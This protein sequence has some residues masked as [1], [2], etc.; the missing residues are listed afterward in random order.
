MVVLQVYIKFRQRRV[1]NTTQEAAGI[2]REQVFVVDVMHQVYLAVTV[3]GTREPVTNSWEL[4]PMRIL[5]VF[6]QCS[7][8]VLLTGE[9]AVVPSTGPTYNAVFL[10]PNL[11]FI[12]EERITGV[13]WIV[14]LEMSV[15]IHDFPAN[16]TNEDSVTEHMGAVLQLGSTD[17]LTAVPAA[18]KEVVQLDVRPQFPGVS[19]GSPAVTPPADDCG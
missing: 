2:R 3:Q 13:A 16:E 9:L 19:V 12:I 15:V 5:Y 17:L 8:F 1:L 7:R 18:L 4:P 10:I 6:P 11:N 14:L